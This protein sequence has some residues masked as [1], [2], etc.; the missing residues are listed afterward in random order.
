MPG[1]GVTTTFSGPYSENPGA[2]SSSSAAVAVPSSAVAL[3]GRVYLIDTA[4]GSEWNRTGVDVV[5]QRNTGDNRDLLLLP[6]D[7]WRQSQH[8]WHYGAGQKNLDR[9]DSIPQRY[10]D[11]FG[12]N[13]WDRWK[14]SLL[15]STALM[16]SSP[17]SDVPMF[18]AVH[19]GSL[20]VGAGD[21]LYWYST[22]TGVPA[23]LTPSAADQIIGMTYDGDNVITLHASG[24]V[25][26]S[27]NST[28]TALFGT[29]ANATFIAYVKDYLLVGLNNVLTNITSGTGVTVYTS[30][31]TGFRWVGAAEGLTNIYLLGGAGQQSVVHSTQVN[32]GGTALDPCVVAAMLPDGEVGYSIGGYLGFMFFGTNKGVRMGVLSTNLRVTT[33]SLTLGAIIPTSQPVRCFEGQDR[34]MW[35]G[36]EAMA[37]SSTPGDESASFP[38]S[39]CCGLGRLDLGTFTISDATPAYA[40]DLYT[41]EQAGKKVTAVLT[42]NDKRVFAVQNGGVYIE[43][44]SLVEAGWLTQGL[45]SFSVEDFKTG[46]Y[47]Q[48]KWLPLTGQIS[49]DAS[50]DSASYTRLIDLTIQGSIRSSNVSLNG[51]RFS[52][53]NVKYVLRRDGSITSNG[54][55]LT[56]W[57]MR[58][59]PANGQASRWTIPILN[60]EN[61]QI[62]DSSETRDPLAEF[63]RL[64]SLYETRRLFTLQESGRTYYVQ[65]KNFQWKPTH[66]ASNGQSWQGKFTIVVE[67]IR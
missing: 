9:D 51:Q 18:L 19:G 22:T 55:T 39:D 3:D 33:G 5:Q 14:I 2:A 35:Y 36:N 53:V 10:E 37:S 45:M 49:L 62:N 64:M 59:M 52:R 13:V 28:T 30:P 63:D 8:S 23:I 38:G 34:F 54:P 25:Y 27:S 41:L 66:L 43:Q 60:H 6:Q 12:I 26:K 1:G 11:S 24:K 56:R 58:A 17:T 29:F 65:A 40:N 21:N 15:H 31:V 32:S 47:M 46:L 7:V 57:E 4:E 48:A 50:Y 42:W 44:D 61:L 20:V 16:S 67:E